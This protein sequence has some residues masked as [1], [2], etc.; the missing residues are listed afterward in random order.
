MKAPAV[1]LALAL[2]ATLGASGCRTTME[3]PDGYTVK[4]EDRTAP[5]GYRFCPPGQAKKGHC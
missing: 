1:A 4:V 3:S 2:V 5:G